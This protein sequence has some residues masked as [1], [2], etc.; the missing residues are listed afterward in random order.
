MLGLEMDG[1]ETIS[2][3]VTDPGSTMLSPASL[4]WAGVCGPSSFT[5]FGSSKFS[6]LTALKS[7]KHF[8][9]IT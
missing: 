6:I 4:D 1:G 5:L 7:V 2:D 3:T 8:I 9:G